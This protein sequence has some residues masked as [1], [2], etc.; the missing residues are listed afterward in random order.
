MPLSTPG[1]AFVD[2]F[3]NMG[4]VQLMSENG[5]DSVVEVLEAVARQI[6]V[7]RPAY[8]RRVRAVM[9]RRALAATGAVVLVGLGVAGVA[10]VDRRSD[11]RA[12]SSGAAV[13]NAAPPSA[14]EG[15]GS[16]EDGST[17]SVRGLSVEVPSGWVVD[18]TSVSAP[19]MSDPRGL[20]AVTM[21]PLDAEAVQAPGCDAQV[22]ASLV[23]ASS[24]SGVFVWV[25]EAEPKGSIRL[26]PSLIDPSTATDYPCASL[27]HLYNVWFEEDGRL[28][29]IYIG[30]GQEAA[31]A[32]VNLAFDVAN[33][34][35]VSE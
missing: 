1:G 15:A 11:E 22:P 35:K 24:P 30:V 10:Q 14:V 12:A 33:S 3:L 32:D 2:R 26:R 34:L 19:Y 9:V 18:D 7:G 21:T 31:T 6:K 28:L 13:S 20:L 4:E 25:V 5:N 23:T 29:G 27:M 17:A 16:A 8:R